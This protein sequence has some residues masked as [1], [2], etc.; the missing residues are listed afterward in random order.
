LAVGTLYAV[1]YSD[2][3]PS[4]YDS[5]LQQRWCLRRGTLCLEAGFR[6]DP[7]RA[8][9]FSVDVESDAGP[10]DS[11]ALYSVTPVYAGVLILAIVP[12][13]FDIARGFRRSSRRRQGLCLGCAYDLKGNASG[14][15]PECGRTIG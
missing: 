8:T 7:A 4:I 14:V 15:C 3:L 13:L 10:L 2:A 11:D 12:T 1:S 9:R 6:I 5:K